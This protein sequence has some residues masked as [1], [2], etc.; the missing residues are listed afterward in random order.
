MTL[1]IVKDGQHIGD[2]PREVEQEG[3][4]AV[5]AWYREQLAGA[6]PEPVPITEQY[7]EEE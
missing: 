7:G 3:P 6:E 2:V 1:R 5:R 4:D